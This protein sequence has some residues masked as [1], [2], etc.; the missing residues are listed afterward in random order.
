MKK[1]LIILLCVCGN[2]AGVQASWGFFAHRLI[3]RMAIVL[4]PPEM[5]GFYKSHA[6]YLAERAVAPDERRYAV[7][8]EAPRHYIDI[9]VY[10]DSAIHKMPRSWKQAVNQY[11]EDTLMAYGTCPWNIVFMKERLTKAMAQQRW[12]QILKLSAEIGHYIGDAHVPLHTTENYNGQLS[13]Q[14]GIHG[15]WESRLPE[16]FAADYDFFL[17]PAQYI[18]HPELAA[19]QAVTESHQGLEAVLQWE[20]ALTAKYGDHRKFSYESRN[21]RNVKVYAYDFSSAYHQALKGQVEQRMR[22]A[23]QCTANFWYTCWVDAGQP[24]LTTS[25]EGKQAIEQLIGLEQQEKAIW[26]HQKVK[27]RKH[28]H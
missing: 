10:G 9:D 24:S 6:D 15:F 16:L 11:S 26:K 25:E 2:I 17:S 27:G 7:D 28:E 20:K 1:L 21:G 8:W 3:N 12:A 18:E 22:C 5:F 13:G 4:L 23:I 19:W 14:Y